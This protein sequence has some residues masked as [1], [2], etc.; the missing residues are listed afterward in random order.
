MAL[1]IENL[2][3]TYPNGVK[4]LNGVSLTI[5]VGVFGLLGPNGAGKSSLM[6]TLATLQDADEGSVSFDGLN[7]LDEKDQLRRRLGYLPQDFG[8][9]PKA[10]PLQLLEHFAVFEGHFSQNRTQGPG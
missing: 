2:K 1:I 7:V 9:Y 6:R 8:F 10:R 4:A 3:K 5:P